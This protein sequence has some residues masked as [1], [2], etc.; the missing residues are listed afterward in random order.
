MIGTTFDPWKLDALE[1]VKDWLAMKMVV[2]TTA[3][4]GSFLGEITKRVKC[5]MLY[6]HESVMVSVE[7][8]VGLERK[9]W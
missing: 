1:I 2:G 5:Y 4:L 9:I 3:L 6:F 8:H 7:E